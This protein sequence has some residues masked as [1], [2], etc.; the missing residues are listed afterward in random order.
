MKDYYDRHY[1]DYYQRTVSADSSSFLSQFLKILK[2]E[3]SVLDIGCGSGRDLLWLKQNGM[4]P[5][6]LEQSKGLAE[7][8]KKHSGCDVIDADFELVDFST[9]QVDGILFSASMV[10][11]AHEQVHIVIR[12]A[13]QALKQTGFMYVS[14][15]EG[16]S[17]KVDSAGRRFYLWRDDALRVVFRKLNLEVIHFA[18]SGSVMGRDVVWLGYVLE[19]KEPEV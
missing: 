1:K 15:K 17:M 18:R 19:K 9:M 4:K 7:L 6:G 10:H 14:L 12:H 11:I 16:D 13:L 5:V 2:P 3:S 8:A